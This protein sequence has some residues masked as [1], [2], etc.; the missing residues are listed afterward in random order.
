MEKQ[1]GGFDENDFY[2][3]LSMRKIVSDMEPNKVNPEIGSIRNN[4]MQ[5]GGLAI[6][7]LSSMK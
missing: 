6:R 5:G 2:G 1:G 7:R 3:T 4:Y